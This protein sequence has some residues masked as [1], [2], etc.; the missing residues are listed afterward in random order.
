MA[1]S[2]HPPQGIAF[3]EYGSSSLDDVLGLTPPVFVD[4]S[5]AYRQLEYIRKYLDPFSPGTIAIETHYIDRDYMED[6]GVFYSR[7]LF[8]YP[9]HCRRVLFFKPPPNEVE[10]KLNALL[11]LARANGREDFS[12]S[13]RNFSEAN[14]LGFMIVKPLDGSPVGRTV[15]RPYDE[16]TKN[17]STRRFPCT[18]VYHAHFLGVPL[19]VRGMPFQQQDIGVSAC[20]TTAL[21][22]ALAKVREHEELAAATPA[23]ITMLAARY[24]MPHGRA[25]PSEGLSLDQMCQAVN[26]LGVS[27]DLLRLT[28]SRAARGYLYSAIKSGIPPVLILDRDQRTVRH[29]VTVAGMKCNSSGDGTYLGAA[30]SG[31]DKARELTALYVHDDRIG[32]YVDAK[33]VPMLNPS[34]PQLH[35]ELQDG[36]REEWEISHMLLPMHNKIRL[37]FSSLRRIAIRVIEEAIAYLNF[38]ARASEDFQEA[39]ENISVDT[40]VARGHMY[41]EGLCLEKPTPDPRIFDS[42]VRTTSLTRY[43]G[44]VR[45]T[46]KEGSGIDVLV[47]TTGTSRN[48]HCLAVVPLDSDEPTLDFAKHMAVVCHCTPLSI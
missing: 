13:C 22:S 33:F 38:R 21:W 19:H 36:A 46:Q 44:V 11:D 37:S 29:A 12:A 32:P 1:L 47:D 6:H 10:S 34:P 42:L 23:Q 8:T 27:P 24:N 18:R 26:A 35:I 30:A 40:W 7:N 14:F 31:I 5:T 45:V 15:L 43:V 16:Q 20:A 48:M 25:M 2:R 9:N 4:R 17:G 41:L 39:G 3:H 28:D